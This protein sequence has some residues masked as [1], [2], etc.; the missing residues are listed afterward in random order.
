MGT[1]P[2]TSATDAEGRC[3][4]Q[5]LLGLSSAPQGG[6]EIIDVTDPAKPAPFRRGGNASGAY[7]ASTGSSSA[8]SF[9]FG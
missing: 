6:L 4:D 9:F 2:R 8:S 3:H 1:D 7:A 5:G